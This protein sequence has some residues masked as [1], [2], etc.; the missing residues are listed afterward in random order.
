MEYMSTEI[1]SAREAMTIFKILGI[2]EIT[3]DRQRKN[4]TQVFELPIKQMYQNLLPKPLRFA[5]Y[6]AGYV[7]N[8]S[9]YNS[10]PY[11]INKTKKRPAGTNG[12]HFET[13]ERILIPSWEERLIYL[14][15][16]IIKNYYQ[17]P[18]YLMNDYVIECLKQEREVNNDA[19]QWGY[20]VNPE[21]TPVDDIKVIINGHR[22][23]L[24]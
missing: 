13:I 23:N 19:L 9:P 18:T 5:T 8:V 20:F 4:G 10:S 11:Q 6:K 7:R 3:T 22:Y 1:R 2:K 17:K 21:S 15:K 12:Y 16:F 24:S 14:A